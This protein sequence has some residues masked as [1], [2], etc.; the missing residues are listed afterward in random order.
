VGHVHCV[1]TTALTYDAAS[2]VNLN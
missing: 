1:Y 2:V